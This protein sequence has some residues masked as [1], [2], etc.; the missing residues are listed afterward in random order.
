MTEGSN[1]ECTR[2]DAKGCARLRSLRNSFA[3]HSF[4]PHSF[5]PQESAGALNRRDH[6]PGFCP[7]DFL[8]TFVL[9]KKPSVRLPAYSRPFVSIRG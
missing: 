7:A 2:I 3:P 5:A 8:V 6:P 1:R 4:A 9:E